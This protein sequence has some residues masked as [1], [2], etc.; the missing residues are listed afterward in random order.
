MAIPLPKESGV[1]SP[2]S[3]LVEEPNRQKK[4]RTRIQPKADGLLNL[5]V[6]IF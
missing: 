4:A 1:S 5:L 2:A 3:E 6:I